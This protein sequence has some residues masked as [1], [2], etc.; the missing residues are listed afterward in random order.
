MSGIAFFWVGWSGFSV[1]LYGSVAIRFGPLFTTL[2]V[3]FLCSRNEKESQRKRTSTAPRATSRNIPSNCRS[4]S[5]R[6]RS[7]GLPQC[8]STHTTTW[9]LQILPST[10]ASHAESTVIE[11]EQQRHLAHPKPTQNSSG[12][13]TTRRCGSR[14]GSVQAKIGNAWSQGRRHATPAQT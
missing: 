6:S 13:T 5:T 9:C 3:C 1:T 10:P 7:R 12:T 2:A 4:P 8:T 11:H 14:T